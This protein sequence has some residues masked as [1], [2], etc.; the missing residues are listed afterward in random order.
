MSRADVPSAVSLEVA[1]SINAGHIVVRA[2]VG[3]DVLSFD[4]DI[5]L[6]DGIGKR[7]LTLTVK[8]FCAI[9]NAEVREHASDIV[10]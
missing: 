4:R 7:A 8:R 1:N 10:E 2:Y 9:P 3:D 6:N 5:L